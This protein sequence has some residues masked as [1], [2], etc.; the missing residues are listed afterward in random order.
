MRR[1]PWARPSGVCGF[2]HLD[3][4]GDDAMPKREVPGRQSDPLGDDLV[5]LLPPPPRATD[6]PV[7]SAQFMGMPL[8]TVRLRLWFT[9]AKTPRT[10]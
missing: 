7:V 8:T 5:P 9:R 10:R 2:V 6:A 4:M 3:P 1:P